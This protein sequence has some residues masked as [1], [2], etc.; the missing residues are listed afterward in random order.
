MDLTH[1]ANLAEIF[2]VAVIVI[3]LIYVA[4]Q[5]RQTNLMMKNAAASERL[6]RDY[7][8][9]VPIIENRDVAELWVKGDQGF[10]DLDHVD[11][12]RLIF[13]ERRAVMLW[14]HLYQMQKQGLFSDANW[15]E[16]IWVIRIIGRRQAVRETW[17]LF[18][19]NFETA[20]RDFIEEQFAIADA[21]A[22]ESQ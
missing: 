2:G 11:Q 22:G 15:Q 7:D 21:E 20:F 5:L 14:H 6:E 16:T 13:F 10:A 4:K 12:Q 9:V 1:L 17:R 3:S 18:D 19:R 8:L